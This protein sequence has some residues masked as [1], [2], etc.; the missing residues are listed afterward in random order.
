MDQFA[1][2]HLDVYW[3]SIEFVTVA[4][5]LLLALPQ[6]RVYVAEQ[7]RRAAS[8]LPLSIAGAAAEGSAS[9]RARLYAAAQHCATESAVLLDIIGAS[10]RAEKAPRSNAHTLLLR[11]TAMLATLISRSDRPESA[12]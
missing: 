8:Q 6:D 4:E 3:T 7:L 9:E 5:Q 10:G 11:I 1:H 2:E 12:P